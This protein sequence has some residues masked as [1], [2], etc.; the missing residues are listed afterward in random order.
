MKT[1]KEKIKPI[2]D[3]TL[4]FP[5]SI[6]VLV[7][8]VLSIQLFMSNQSE[9]GLSKTIKVHPIINETSTKQ[10]SIKMFEEKIER[11][12]IAKRDSAKNEII[13]KS[14]QSKTLNQIEENHYLSRDYNSAPKVIGS[15]SKYKQVV[16]ITTKVKARLTQSITNL[17]YMHP[18][19]ATII[20]DVSLENGS[21]IKLKGS[22]LIGNAYAYKNKDRLYIKF[23]EL[24]KNNK[25]YSINAIAMENNTRGLQAEVDNKIP[26]RIANKLLETA[27]SIVDLY[28]ENAT[29]EFTQNIESKD[30]IEIQ[31]LETERILS[32]D[33]RQF[34]LFF[35]RGLEIN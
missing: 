24:V 9:S 31:N 3:S 25:T 5:L 27:T 32:V 30:L 16:P 23:N 29:N 28:T 15:N 8:V 34:T 6:V 1:F 35:D 33:T 22:H 10:S 4:F 17:D 18:V 12:K 19:H 20:E 14:T 2:L 26:Q 13:S 7:V 11:V 21:N